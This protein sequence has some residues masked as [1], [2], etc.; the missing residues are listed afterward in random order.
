[1]LAYILD[2]FLIV[3][4]KDEARYWEYRTKRLVLVECKYLGS[5][6]TEQYERHQMMGATLARRLDRQFHFGLVVE[7]DRDPRFARLKEQYAQWDQVREKLRAM[8]DN[9]V[10]SLAR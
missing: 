6:S 4:R 7:K 8:N 3:R 1:M 2:T 10:K 5:P 9:H